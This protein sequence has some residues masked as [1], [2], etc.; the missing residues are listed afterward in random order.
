MAAKGGELWKLIDLDAAARIGA[1]YLGLKSSTVYAAPELFYK[2]KQAAS[3][4]AEARGP[5]E[6]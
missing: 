4:A 6:P 3:A 5:S 2:H 1:G